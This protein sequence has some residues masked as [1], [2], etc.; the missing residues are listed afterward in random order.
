MRKL[1]LLKK[2]DSLSPYRKLI[3]IHFSYSL[4][5]RDWKTSAFFVKYITA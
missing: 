1:S 2:W 5:S 4:P 3:F